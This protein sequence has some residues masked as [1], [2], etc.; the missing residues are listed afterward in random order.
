MST[1]RSLE[2]SYRIDSPISTS[3][4][5]F[6]KEYCVCS[7][8]VPVDCD[9]RILSAKGI[10]DSNRVAVYISVVDAMP[11]RKLMSCPETKDGMLRVKGY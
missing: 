8:L 2:P 4:L 6:P 9:G 11:F 5:A 3:M 7:E 1:E 10:K